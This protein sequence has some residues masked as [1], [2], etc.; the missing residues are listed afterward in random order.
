MDLS[1]KSV[2]V[3]DDD[4]DVAELVQTI[5]L[6]E[7][8]KV[9]CLYHAEPK[10]REGCDRLDRPDVVLLAGGGRVLR[11]SVRFRVRRLEPAPLPFRHAHF[12]PRG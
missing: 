2:V 3:V 1:G 12:A 8:F 5:L 4:L 10:R 6:I 7:G 11:R 9:S